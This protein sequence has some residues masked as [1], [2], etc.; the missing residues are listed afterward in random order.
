L[1]LNGKDLET[2]PV[3][4]GDKEVTFTTRLTAGSHQL[5]PVFTDAAGNEIGAY[6][7]IIT[8]RP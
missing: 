5:A 7:A 4:P 8:Q 6:Y 1:R 3:Q 2:K